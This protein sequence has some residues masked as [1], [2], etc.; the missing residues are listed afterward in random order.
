MIYYRNVDE[1]VGKMRHDIT[2]LTSQKDALQTALNDANAAKKKLEERVKN[3][4]TDAK[5]AYET[6]EK[7]LLD[8]RRILKAQVD[9]ITAKYK[10]EKTARAV[11]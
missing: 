8:E 4:S 7:V 10:Q 1:T 2:V 5:L 9:E 6:R 3:V 11:R